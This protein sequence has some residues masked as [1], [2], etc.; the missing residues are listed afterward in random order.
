MPESKSDFR[1]LLRYTLLLAGFLFLLIN[2]LSIV[3]GNPW[4]IPPFLRLY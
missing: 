3:M 1:W 4:L 2:H